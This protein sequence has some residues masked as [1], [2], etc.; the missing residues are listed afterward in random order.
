MFLEKML[1][2]SEGQF[3]FC[4]SEQ[5]FIPFICGQFWRHCMAAAELEAATLHYFFLMPFQTW[6]L[7]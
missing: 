5:C 4:V 6:Q 1:L 2:G 7:F 3:L